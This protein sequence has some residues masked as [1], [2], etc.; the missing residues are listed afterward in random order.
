MARGSFKVI[1]A[2]GCIV[3]E[4]RL[5]KGKRFA[6]PEPLSHLIESYQLVRITIEKIPDSKITKNLGL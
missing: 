6:I 1:K 5:T 3:Y 2:N 4:A